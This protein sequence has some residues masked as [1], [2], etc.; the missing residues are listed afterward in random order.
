MSTKKIKLLN[1]LFLLVFLFAT[2]FINFFH[3]EK[4]VMDNDNCPACNFMHSTM[5]TSQINFFHLPQLYF[6]DILKTFYSFSYQ[7]IFPINPTSR[8]PPQI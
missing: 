4:N 5:A 1:I 3:T 7:K 8:S 6:L 2:L